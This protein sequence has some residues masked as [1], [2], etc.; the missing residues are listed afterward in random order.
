MLLSS[1]KNLQRTYYKDPLK[2]LELT[3]LSLMLLSLP[4][5][6]APKNIFLILF[7][8]TS[9]YRQYLRKTKDPW[10]LWDW[11]FLSY[12]A[13]AFLSAAFAG[14]HHGAEWGGFRSFLIWTGFAW[15]L[16]RTQYE[17]KEITWIIWITILG[18]LHR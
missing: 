3:F 6:E 2:Y 13:S 17:S 18:T 15:L 1:F 16:S 12:I 14:I 11:I 10:R 7:L 8:A 9:L 5:L 4:S